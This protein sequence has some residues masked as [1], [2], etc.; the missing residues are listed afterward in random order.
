MP[1]S[2]HKQARKILLEPYKQEKWTKEF[3]K[4]FENLGLMGYDVDVLCSLYN[5][6]SNMDYIE[7]VRFLATT[8]GSE[9]KPL[10]IAIIQ[11][12]LKWQEELWE[13]QNGE[14]HP[15]ECVVQ[16]RDF[17]K[18]CLY[19]ACEKNIFYENCLSIAEEVMDDNALALYKER[20]PFAIPPSDDTE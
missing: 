1:P 15:G 5:H 14:H 12:G 8:V 18:K 10:L 3:K 16:Q 13:W 7:F 20:L 6:S 4:F 19:K 11:Q 17:M 2:P 9:N